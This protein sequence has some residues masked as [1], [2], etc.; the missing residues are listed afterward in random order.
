MKRILLTILLAV[1]LLPGLATAGLPVSS[2][3][4]LELYK[5]R[6]A[7]RKIEGKLRQKM[8]MSIFDGLQRLDGGDGLQRLDGGN[9]DGQIHANV[10]L[11]C[12]ETADFLYTR[13]TPTEV[14]YRQGSRP[15]LE[16]TVREVTPDC[17]TDRQKVLALLRYVRDIYQQRPSDGSSPLRGGTEEQLLES[18]PRLCEHQS[19]L[20]VALWQVAGFPARRVG[21]FVGGH[22][23]TEVFFEDKWAYIDIRGIY[24]LKPDGKF[25]STWEIWTHPEWIQNQSE[26]VIA[27]R[28]PEGDPLLG[29]IYRWDNTP[30]QYFHPNEITTIM[31]YDI[32]QA[33]EYSYR[34]VKR[35][36]SGA[37]PE[38]AEQKRQ[39]AS[40]R[41]RIF[42]GER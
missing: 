41:R 40:W 28:V 32:N 10:V 29:D 14:E 16:A 35:Q 3:E 30:N 38:E 22:A 17:V 8:F 37:T 42:A 33:A 15:V 31:N 4:E 6:K 26:E 34:R 19:R 12:P 9:V 39:V 13:F 27:D 7:Y 2:W 11:L 23:V 36:S 20:L 25:A 5:G 18:R 1:L 21:H 24:V